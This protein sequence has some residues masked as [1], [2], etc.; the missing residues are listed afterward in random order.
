MATDRV[1]PCSVPAA[2]AGAVV[3]FV[4]NGLPWCNRYTVPREK[5]SAGARFC[6]LF[7]WVTPAL[8]QRPLRKPRM[9]QEI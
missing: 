8:S 9:P 5:S 4:D 6:F 7:L 2:V 3:I 1:E